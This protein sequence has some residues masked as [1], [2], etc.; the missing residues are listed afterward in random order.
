VISTPD[1]VLR[2]DREGR[3]AG[4]PTAGDDR[5]ATAGLLDVLDAGSRQALVAAAAEPPAAS[6]ELVTLDGRVL[7]AVVRED[8]RREG[9]GVTV[10]LRDVSRYARASEQLGSMAVALA[11]R[12]RDLK[13]LYEAAAE[14]DTTQDLTGIARTTAQLVGAY[15]EADRVE[16]EVLDEVVTWPDGAPAPAADRHREVHRLGTARGTLGQLRWWRRSPLL[17]NEAETLPLLISRAGIGLDHALLLSSAEQRAARDELTGLLNRAG[18]RQALAALVAPFPVALLDLDRF[19]AINDV[20]GHAEGDRVLR[21]VAAILST[22][23]DTDVKARWG[24]EEFLVA[25]D[26]ASLERAVLWLGERLDEVRASVAV[27]SG[28]VSFSA[29]VAVVGDDGLEAALRRA[30]EALYRAK[31]AGRSRVETAVEDAGR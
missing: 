13:V 28:A 18:A 9:E 16:V 25:L 19:K 12:N 7:D 30:D 14:L 20:H 21:E 10:S 3:P 2:L 23:R 15:L 1:A 5:A 11:R 29:G 31:E 4:D 17:S 27:P 24:G 22:G 26:H 8:R 6:L